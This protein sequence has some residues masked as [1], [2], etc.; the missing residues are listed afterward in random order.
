MWTQMNNRLHNSLNELQFAA[1]QREKALFAAEGGGAGLDVS[2][3][4]SRRV[5]PLYPM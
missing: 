2:H 1:E 4:S 3:L 5:S